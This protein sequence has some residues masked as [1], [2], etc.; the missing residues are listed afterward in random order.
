[1]SATELRQLFAAALSD[2]PPPRDVVTAAA[3]AGRA[4]RR[5]RRAGAAVVASGVAAAS[6][7]GVLAAVRT[8]ETTTATPAAPRSASA[9]T[10][11]PSV[12]IDRARLEPRVLA[13]L[14]AEL[15]YFEEPVVGATTSVVDGGF[16]TVVSTRDGIG[17]GSVEVTV[18]NRPAGGATSCSAVATADER[19][20]SGGIGSGVTETVVRGPLRFTVGTQRRELVLL[21]R[22]DTEVTL[23][24]RNVP[25]QDTRREARELGDPAPPLRAD[26]LVRVGRQTLRSLGISVPPGPAPRDPRDP[27]GVAPEVVELGQRI[28]PVVTRALG[29]GARVT[30]DGSSTGARATG[31]EHVVLRGRWHEGSAEGSVVIGLYAPG[32]SVGA[33]VQPGAQLCG[34]PPV[35]SRSFRWDTCARRL[36]PGSAATVRI[37]VGGDPVAKAITATAVRG[38]EGTVSIS[39]STGS[40]ERNPSSPGETEPVAPTLRSLPVDVDTL[41]ALVLDPRIALR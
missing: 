21:R 26:A 36:V 4:T 28:S 37:G 11:A 31:Y 39:L 5:R 41:V 32:I 33:E 3:L 17:P 10:A 15:R 6:V 13:L 27:R 19:C 1:M 29:A 35:R 23:V 12:P 9:T 24:S 40:Y 16:R 30:W 34:S 8:G 25:R 38:A 2:A 14:R 20:R 22:G 7:A 18:R